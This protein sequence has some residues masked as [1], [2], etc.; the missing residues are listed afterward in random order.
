[1]RII[2]A[3]PLLFLT[4]A[5]GSC[6]YGVKDIASV[7]DNP[8]YWQDVR[9]LLN[10]HCVVCHGWP[11]DRGAP[12][13]FRVDVYEDTNGIKGAHAYGAM[14]NDYVQRNLMPPGVGDTDGVGPNGKAM[15]Q[16]WIDS[17]MPE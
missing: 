11:P 15:L 9:P 3:G 5:I 17:E 8:T 4:M 6:H 1:M 13:K 14:I 2:F 10:D 16:K 12:G 7:P